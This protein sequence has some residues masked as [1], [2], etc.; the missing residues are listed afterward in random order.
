V[1]GFRKGC[2]Y[3][4]RGSEGQPGANKDIKGLQGSNRVTCDLKGPQKF[5]PEMQHVTH[6]NPRKE[7]TVIEENQEMR[8][9]LVK[10]NEGVVGEKKL[11]LQFCGGE[12]KG[13]QC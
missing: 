2:D 5:F 4:T 7:G 10:R 6:R 3:F 1:A 12:G 9:L 11:S 8:G 13:G